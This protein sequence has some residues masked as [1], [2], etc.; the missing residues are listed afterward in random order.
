MRVLPSSFGSDGV[1]AYKEIEEFDEFD[2]EETRSLLGQ[3]T[4][5]L[6]DLKVSHHA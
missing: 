3:E 6:A 5:R 4:K 2:G 1:R